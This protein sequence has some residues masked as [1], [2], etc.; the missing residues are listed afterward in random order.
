MRLLASNDARTEPFGFVRVHFTM[1]DITATPE[2]LAGYAKALSHP[3]RIRVLQALSEKG[4]CQC[5]EVV[6]VIGLAQSTVSQHLK[7]LK[8]AGLV[9]GEV[10]GP[11]TCYCL[12]HAGLRAA[13]AAVANLFGCLCGDDGCC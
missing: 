13:S 8:E 1:N 12:N 4:T 3:A 7:V 10:D 11:R 2:T 9:D 6:D 5:G